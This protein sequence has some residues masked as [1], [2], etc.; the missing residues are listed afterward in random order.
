M[1]ALLGL[2]WIGLSGTI[3]YGEDSI[4]LNV[5]FQ[6]QL[7]LVHPIQLPLLC[8]ISGPR[9]NSCVFL[10]S[11][12]SLIEAITVSPGVSER[13]LLLV[14]SLL[15]SLGM[16]DLCG[17]LNS[18]NGRPRDSHQIAKTIATLVFLMN[19]F[20][21]TITWWHFE[22]WTLFVM[23]CPLLVSTLSI[24]HYEGRVKFPRLAVTIAAGILI[25]PGVSGPFAV[26][27]GFLLLVFVAALTFNWIRG[28]I[29]TGESSPVLA[30]IFLLGGAIV[31]W[32]TLP[33]YLILHAALGS[34]NYANSGDIVALFAHESV[35]TQPLA[36]MQLLAFN[37]IAEV[38]D[39]FPWIFGLLPILIVAS[40]VYPAVL[41][42]ACLYVPRT[43]G[44]RILV[45]SALVLG[46]YS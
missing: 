7:E 8:R 41:C 1:T 3:L 16:F 11:G 37:W 42:V 13:I 38:P 12:W 21:L 29:A 28:A 20:T 34:N 19:P 10:R 23:F 25:G 15:G 43:N 6:L 33:D 27:I 22:N 35:G 44:L 26:D 39:A 17:T 2:L 46:L 5:A 32:A 18:I 4:A 24:N 9:R 36:V 30:I 40:F 45:P 31:L 14:L